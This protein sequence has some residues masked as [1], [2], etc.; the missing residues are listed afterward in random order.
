MRNL[1]LKTE[2]IKLYQSNI[3]K[4]QRKSLN[5]DVSKDRFYRKV[6]VAT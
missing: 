5:F 1:G 2:N 4:R 3:N 6:A